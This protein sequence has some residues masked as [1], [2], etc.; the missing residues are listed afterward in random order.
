M[1]VIW[2]FGSSIV[3]I[4]LPVLSRLPHKAFMKTKYANKWQ[5]DIRREGV[6]TTLKSQAHC[7]GNLCVM[8]FF[9]CFCWVS[10]AF[11]YRRFNYLFWG[12]SIQKGKNGNAGHNTEPPIRLKLLKGQ[13]LYL[14]LPCGQV[15][16]TPLGQSKIIHSCFA[17]FLNG[18]L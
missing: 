10:L 1:S 17:L 13:G 5:S 14:I 16:K 2:P 15:S 12:K 11:N 18:V 7:F 8:R 9:N 6:I 3:G 4:I